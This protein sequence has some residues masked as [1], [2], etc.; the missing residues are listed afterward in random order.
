MPTKNLRAQRAFS[1]IELLI[2]IT[3]LSILASFVTYT[4]TSG[5]KKAR[6]AQRKSNLRMVKKILEQAKN[7]C[8]NAAYYPATNI[9]GVGSSYSFHLNGYL[10]GSGTNYIKTPL[11]NDPKYPNMQYEFARGT[12]A[13]AGTTAKCINNGTG[14]SNF[15]GVNIWIL[16]A[17]L[18]SNDPETAKSYADC[19][20]EATNVSQTPLSQ[21]P[22]A[23]DGYY[24]VCSE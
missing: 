13:V 21:T 11:P 12:T 1:L 23:T 15:P 6:D 22:S 20:T 18:E 24:Y 7:D 8:A 4:L 3:I 17:K 2:A 19:Q 14:A 16:R 5:Q 10:K 9:G